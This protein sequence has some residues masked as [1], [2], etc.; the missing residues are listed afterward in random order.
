LA[1]ASAGAF[2]GQMMPVSKI[3]IRKSRPNCWKRISGAYASMTAG[4]ASAAMSCWWWIA[5]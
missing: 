1:S 5:F 3:C 4:A 2:H